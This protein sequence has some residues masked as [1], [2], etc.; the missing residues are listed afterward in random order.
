[1]CEPT[2]PNISQ[3]QTAAIRIP[4]PTPILRM[5]FDRQLD[6]LMAVIATVIAFVGCIFGGVPLEFSLLASACVLLAGFIFGRRVAE[7]VSSPF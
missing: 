7:I 6:I 3:P 2:L 1:M 5:S 4:S